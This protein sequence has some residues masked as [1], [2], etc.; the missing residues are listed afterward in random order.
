MFKPKTYQEETLNRLAAFLE[1]ARFDGPR[2]AFDAAPR[3]VPKPWNKPYAPLE[4][5]SDTPYTC[6]RL[7]TGGGKTHLAAL[8]VKLGGDNKYRAPESAPENH[9]GTQA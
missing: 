8:V 6:L 9:R 1:A 3:A 2:A 7:P 4:H 5:L